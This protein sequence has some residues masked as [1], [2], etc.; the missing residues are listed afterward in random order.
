MELNGFPFLFGLAQTL[1]EEWFARPV[2]ENESAGVIHRAGGNV[3]ISDINFENK[4]WMALRGSVT[5]APDRRLSGNLEVG[6][7]EAMIQASKNRRLNTM[8]GPPKEGF[9]W[10]TV[11]VGGGAGAPM[12]NFK[13]LYESAVVAETPA[14][15]NKVPSFEELTSPK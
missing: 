9:R 1:D 3:T 15:A 14:P 8:F 10:L 11:K 4:S 5:M 12:D 2:F 6:V 13:E 7:A